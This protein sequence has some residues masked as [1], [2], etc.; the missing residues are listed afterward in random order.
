MSP[1]LKPY[2]DNPISGEF[3]LLFIILH[4]SI[5]SLFLIIIVMIYSWFII[6]LEYLFYQSEGR[7]VFI[8]FTQ[9]LSPMLGIW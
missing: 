5:S 7:V 1:P 6:L 8:L 4:V 2:C 9:M 3:P